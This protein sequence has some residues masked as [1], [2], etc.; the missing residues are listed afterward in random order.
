MKEV[1]VVEEGGTLVARL[2]CEIDHHSVKGLREVI[3]KRL[4]ESRARTLVM[5]FS[6]VGFMDSSGIGLILG[7]AEV[8]DRLGSHV[9]LRALSPSML[10][11]VRMSGVEKIKNVKVEAEESK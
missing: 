8:A 7:R 10:R 5:D 3:D 6:D 9:R 11:I 4:C 2:N 1:S